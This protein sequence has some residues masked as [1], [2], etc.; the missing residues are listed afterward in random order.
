MKPRSLSR[1]CRAP[2]RAL[3]YFVLPMG[4]MKVK[5]RSFPL[6]LILVLLLLPDFSFGLSNEEIQKLQ[7]MLI[8]KPTGERIA[9]W[10]EKFIGTPYD[11]DPLGEY[12]TRAT[13]VAD[14]RVDC[15]YL[16]FRVVELSLTRTPEEAIQ[17]ALDKRFHT[18]GVLKDGRV[19]NYDNRFEYGEDM[20]E[21]GKWGK[22]VTGE[23]RYTL[24][25]KGS[26][27]KDFVDILPSQ[28]LLSGIGRLRS[29]DILF[30]IKKPEKREVGEIV[31]HIG[32]LKVEQKEVYLIHASG[33]KERGGA[34]KK[35]L[36]KDYISKMPFWGVKITRFY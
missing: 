19:L 6:L 29:G 32:V 28:E 8:T 13:L 24:R 34:V 14:E 2:F 16:T 18:K 12:V 25:I 26:R 21:S 27:G 31:G 17:M 20:I 4:T 15:M 36:L 35:V 11:P 1:E 10:A 22:E 33:T 30:F 5:S 7:S 9:F 3:F 23:W